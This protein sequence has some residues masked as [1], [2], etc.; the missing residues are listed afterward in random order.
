M[1]CDDYISTS[2]VNEPEK[3]SEKLV[4][5]PRSCVSTSLRAFLARRVGTSLFRDKN[6]A[7]LTPFFR[8]DDYND[9]A[10]TADVIY[11]IHNRD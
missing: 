8:F 9:I 11:F 7:L 3:R 1:R 6:P 4:F 5:L 2:I 10:K